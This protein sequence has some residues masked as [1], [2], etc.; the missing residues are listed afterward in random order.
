[1]VVSVEVISGVGVE[2]SFGLSAGVVAVIL[3]GD[4][5]LSGSLSVVSFIFVVDMIS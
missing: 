5:S 2:V 3:G 4:R 1:M